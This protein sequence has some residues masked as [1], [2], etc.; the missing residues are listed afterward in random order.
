MLPNCL[1]DFWN[2]QFV[3][4]AWVCVKFYALDYKNHCG[5]AISTWDDE[6]KM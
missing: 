4:G 1:S 3:V 6:E 5:V 2:E